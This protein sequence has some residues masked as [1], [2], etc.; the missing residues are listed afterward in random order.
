MEL[1]ETA[2]RPGIVFEEKTPKSPL[3]Y[4]SA[5]QELLKKWAV[6]DKNDFQVLLKDKIVR[7]QTK[8]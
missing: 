7:Q 1:N 2:N 3:N 4:T 8:K 5:A 6:T